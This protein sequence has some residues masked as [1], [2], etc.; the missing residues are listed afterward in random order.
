MAVL[1]ALAISMILNAMNFLPVVI[2]IWTPSKKEEKINKASVSPAFGVTMVL[3]IL[4]NILLGTN[5]EPILR[6]IELG[7]K[8][9]Q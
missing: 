9:M 8:L 6:V 3:F 5:Y 2:T 4:G 1:L 7:L